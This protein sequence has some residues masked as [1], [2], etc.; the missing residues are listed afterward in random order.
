MRFRAVS[1]Y[2]VPGVFRR[3]DFGVFDCPPSAH[4]A[5]HLPMQESFYY[6][7]L[8]PLHIGVDI[9]AQFPHR[10][11]PRRG[12]KG[13]PH[14]GNL[15]HSPFYSVASWGFGKTPFLWGILCG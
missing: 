15:H 10:V 1:S 3:S 7:F 12:R 14:T 2:Q 13:P 8:T 9:R 11:P 4:V 5:F 6:S